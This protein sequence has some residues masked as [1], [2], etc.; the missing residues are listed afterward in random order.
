MRVSD[1]DECKL[2]GVC[3]QN[4]NNTKGSF[5]CSCLPGYETEYGST[6]HCKLD[7][8]SQPEPSLIF[9]NRNDLRQLDMHT[10]HYRLLL[11]NTKSAVA[12]D[13]DYDKHLLYYSD[14]AD[15][16]IFV[17]DIRGDKPKTVLLEG[18]KTPDGLALDWVHQNLYWTDTADNTISVYS[19]HTKSRKTLFNQ[20]LDEPRAI[21]VDPRANQKYLYWTDWG[22]I[23][24]IERSGLD[25][26]ARQT[27]AVNG[28]LVWP[29]GL[30]IGEL[31]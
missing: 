14:V 19:L 31:L 17:Y 20:N 25:G 16:K 9:A 1:V 13:L 18:V 26:Q 11:N 5:K 22:M 28:T 2:F 7:L 4:C 27:L 24:K 15:E 29:N 23:P 21:V 6:T 10:G 30:T 8:V 12:L 3:S